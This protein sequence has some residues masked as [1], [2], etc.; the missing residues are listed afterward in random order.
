MAAPEEGLDGFE[1]LEN[2]EYHFCT[3]SINTGNSCFELVGFP[4]SCKH[5]SH[6]GV[7]SI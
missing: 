3:T 1:V 6:R 5:S 4:I 7:F 2:G